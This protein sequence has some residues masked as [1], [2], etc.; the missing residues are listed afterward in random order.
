MTNTSRY[1]AA[2]NENFGPDGKRK[3]IQ[4]HEDVVEKNMQYYKGY[5]PYGKKNVS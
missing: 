1:T 2:H 5:N 3:G 4:G